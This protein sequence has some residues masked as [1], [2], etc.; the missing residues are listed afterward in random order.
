MDG[1]VDA[2]SAAT[3]ALLADT[4]RAGRG[5]GYWGGGE[6]G[7]YG[8]PY[9]NLSSLQ[10]GIHHTDEN[11]KCEGDKTRINTDAKAE[12]VFAGIENIERT[13]SFNR[14]CDRLTDVDQRNTDNQ[15]RAEL[16]TNDQIASIREQMTKDAAAAALCCCKLEAQAAKDHGETQAAI[17]AINAKIDANKEISELRAQLETQRILTQCGCGCGGGVRPCP[18]Q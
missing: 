9:A 17:A 18:P 11:V 6:G 13:F 5:G 7:F 10:H 12:R 4:A 16:R 14:I 1:N 3:L 8:G 15:F 2:G